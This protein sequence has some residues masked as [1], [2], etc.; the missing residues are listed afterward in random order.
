MIWIKIFLGFIFVLEL[1]HIYKLV[2]F[3]QEDFDRAL[4]DKDI[5]KNF[6]TLKD[7]GLNI[8]LESLV[9]T[10]YWMIIGGFILLAIFTGS[11]IILL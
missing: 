2:N 4:N 7:R 9:N 3:N 1:V 10:V 6:Q 5:Q 11:L 8:S